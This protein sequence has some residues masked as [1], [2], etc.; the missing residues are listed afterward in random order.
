MLEKEF[1]YFID[2][3]DDLVIRYPNKFIVIKNN[4][5]IGVYN[6]EIEAYREAQKE[7]EIGTFLIQQCIPGGEE[8]Y[9][10]TFHSR[11]IFV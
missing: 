3:K 7:N 1:Q 10:Q 5:V 11:A 4:D 2:N 9:T 6:S 8:N